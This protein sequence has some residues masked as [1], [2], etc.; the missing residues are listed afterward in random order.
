M[1]WGN[2]RESNTILLRCLSP[3]WLSSEYIQMLFLGD[4]HVAARWPLP[5]PPGVLW[6]KVGPGQWCLVLAP[7]GQERLLS[8]QILLPPSP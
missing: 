1:L 2:P 3:H 7:S 6:P 5:A 8:F 4:G